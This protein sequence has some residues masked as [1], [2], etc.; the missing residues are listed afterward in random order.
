MWPPSSVAYAVGDLQLGVAVP[1]EDLRPK[2][3]YA[4][5]TFAAVY[6][7]R[8]CEKLFDQWMTELNKCVANPLSRPRVQS[9]VNNGLESLQETRR[10]RATTEILSWVPEGRCWVV[11]ERDQQ[12]RPTPRPVRVSYG[13]AD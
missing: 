10:T 2:P 7:I 3:K 4:Q 9:N 1:V 13:P 12:D 6:D 5:I 8:F 11:L